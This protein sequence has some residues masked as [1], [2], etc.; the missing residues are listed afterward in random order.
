[1]VVWVSLVPIIGVIGEDCNHVCYRNL[2]RYSNR[3]AQDA[4]PP[5]RLSFSGVICRHKASEGI[6]WTPDPTASSVEDVR[7]NH[8]H[9]DVLMP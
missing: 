3:Q 6:R 9:L 8:G 5:V 7:V 2:R 4:T 1:M